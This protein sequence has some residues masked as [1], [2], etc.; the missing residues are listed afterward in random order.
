[1]TWPGEGQPAVRAWPGHPRTSGGY[2]HS[3]EFVVHLSLPGRVWDGKRSLERWD[4]G[5]KVPLSPLLELCS[6]PKALPR[7]VLHV[8]RLTQRGT[9]SRRISLR[10]Q[11]FPQ[12]LRRQLEELP[13]ARLGQL[14]AQ[15]A[16]RRLIL[17]ATDPEATQ[18]PVQPLQVQ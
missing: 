7:Q 16:V 11:F 18:V 17:A 6:R 14:Q 12:F 9:I 4:R 1:M 13:E 2:G 10:G 15:Q 5:E 8:P 3:I